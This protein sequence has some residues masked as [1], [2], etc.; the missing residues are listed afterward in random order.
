MGELMAAL[1]R[2]IVTAPAAVQVAAVREGGATVLEMRVAPEDV[3]RIIGR[4]GRTVRALRQVL[5]A[6]ARHQPEAYELEILEED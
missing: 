3:G 2:M 4:Q 5:A 6:A 1:A